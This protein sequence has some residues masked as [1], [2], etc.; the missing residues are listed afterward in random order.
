MDV[1]VLAIDDFGVSGALINLVFE[2]SGVLG[3]SRD[4]VNGD[5]RTPHPSSRD[6]NH[7]HP[8]A[9]D[10]WIASIEA[11]VARRL[12]G[13]LPLRAQFRATLGGNLRR[14]WDRKRALGE[15]DRSPEG[16]LALAVGLPLRGAV[17]LSRRVRVRA[18]LRPVPSAEAAA[19]VAERV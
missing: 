13:P 12:D 1:P 11:G 2:G 8:P 3:S 18:R 19:R 17:R 4:L 14:I 6:A 10:D 9:D 15:Y 5:F 16:Y 7:F